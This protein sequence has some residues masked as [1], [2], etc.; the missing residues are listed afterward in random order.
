MVRS[1]CK[2]G[3]I[4]YASWNNDKYRCI[5]NDKHGIDSDN[6]YHKQ[7]TSEW[8]NISD[9]LFIREATSDEINQLNNCIK[10][11]KYV[12]LSKNTVHELW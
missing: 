11:G 4:Y 6:I 2:P 3:I 9:N 7:N 10:L 5:F 8:C 12:E 1:D